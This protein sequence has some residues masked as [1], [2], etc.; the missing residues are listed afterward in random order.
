MFKLFDFPL[1]IANKC[2]LVYY[3]N[4]RK[5]DR[6]F[7]VTVKLQQNAFSA[8]FHT[9]DTNLRMKLNANEANSFHFQMSSH[10]REKS[11]KTIRIFASFNLNC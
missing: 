9:L 4:N 6:F 5:K 7:P 2:S 8:S 11:N 10:S 1:N 3:I